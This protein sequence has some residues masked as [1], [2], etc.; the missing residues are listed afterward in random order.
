MHVVDSPAHVAQEGSQ[1][2]QVFP[3]ST[4]GLVQEVHVVADPEQV[5]H[6]EL[7]ALHVPDKRY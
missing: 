4:Y 3:N 1:S 6:T 7:Q 2:P 5:V